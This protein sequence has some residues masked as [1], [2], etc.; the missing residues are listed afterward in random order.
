[1]KKRYTFYTD[2]GHGWL[3]VPVK[4]LQELGIMDKIS[5][6]SYLSPRHEVAYLEEDC[7]MSVWFKAWIDKGMTREAINARITDK[8]QAHTPIRNYEPFLQKI[9]Q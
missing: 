9:L 7:D 5:A 8:Y 4:E 6:C 2:P 3:S 1:M